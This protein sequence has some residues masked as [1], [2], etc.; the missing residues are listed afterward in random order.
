M[1][2]DFFLLF[3]F[4]WLDI[5]KV[6]VCNGILNVYL[7]FH[8]LPSVSEK[9]AELVKLQ[10]ELEMHRSSVSQITELK[11]QLDAQKQK[12]NVRKKCQWV[13]SLCRHS[14]PGKEKKP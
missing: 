4:S 5:I 2:F 9:M 1:T 8:S 7:L 13:F 11:T 3:F 10:S 14:S 12:N 6:D